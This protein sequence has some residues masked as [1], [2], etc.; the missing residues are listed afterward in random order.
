[1][2]KEVSW[3]AESVTPVRDADELQHSISANEIRRLAVGGASV[4]AGGEWVQPVEA[5]V[6]WVLRQPR[7]D[8]GAH[9]HVEGR[10]PRVGVHAPLVEKTER[11]EWG[12]PCA[13]PSQRCET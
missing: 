12:D 9:D 7:V 3:M 11:L 13:R 1:V 4:P 10:G 8:E 2:A 6:A 5:E